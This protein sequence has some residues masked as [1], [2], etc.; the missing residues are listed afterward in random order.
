MHMITVC[1]TGRSSCLS[2]E[3]LL[4]HYVENC[5]VG[6]DYS[7]CGELSCILHGRFAAAAHDADFA[8]SQI[9]K[10]TSLNDALI[11]RSYE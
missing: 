5:S 3:F 7:L 8:P 6:F 1:K 2:F 10:L 4:Y 9:N 11:I